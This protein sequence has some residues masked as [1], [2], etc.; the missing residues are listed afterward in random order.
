MAFRPLGCTVAHRG[1]LQILQSVQIK[2]NVLLLHT[3]VFKV[4]Q[5][6]ALWACVWDRV[7]FTVLPFANFLFPSWS[8][9]WPYCV[10]YFW[11]T[12]W[13]TSTL[14]S[15]KP[16]K[17]NKKCPRTNYDMENSWE[18][19]VN[20]EHKLTFDTISLL[21]FD[22][23]ST[24]TFHGNVEL[25]IIT[26]QSMAACAGF[27]SKHIRLHQDP[28]SSQWLRRNDEWKCSLWAVRPVAPAPLIKPYMSNLHR[29]WVG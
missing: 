29:G 20:T 19:V 6:R 14:V 23:C 1:F 22:I 27:S 25:E 21:V 28:C 7:V 10:S 17:R 2:Y 16:N 13:W 18:W 3:T 11:P 26:C 24:I 15:W 9:T 12:V 5:R 8:L 4:K